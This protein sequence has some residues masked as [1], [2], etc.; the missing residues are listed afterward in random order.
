MIP[1]T[2][3]ASQE[4]GAPECEIEIT[5]AMIEAGRAALRDWEGFFSLGPSLEEALVRSVLS[6]VASKNTERE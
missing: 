5:P 3:Q 1:N 6:A 2:P 4:A